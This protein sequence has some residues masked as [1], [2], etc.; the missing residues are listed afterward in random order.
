MLRTLH[1]QHQ[2]AVYL[3]RIDHNRLK[4][5]THQPLHQKTKITSKKLN[6]TYALTA[7][8]GTES[9]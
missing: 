4:G 2:E 9:N 8:P 5:S 6:R 3:G 7:W 1:R